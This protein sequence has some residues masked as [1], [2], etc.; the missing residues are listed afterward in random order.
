ME[1]YI[2][3]IENYN[4]NRKVKA[5]YE[6]LYLV[7]YWKFKKYIHNN[8]F[9]NNILKRENMILK[10]NGFSLWQFL[11]YKIIYKNIHIY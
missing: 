3:I 2:R 6:Y 10:E 9:N 8:G 5:R 11:A 7:N 1:L 4:D